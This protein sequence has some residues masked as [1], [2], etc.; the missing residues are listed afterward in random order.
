M[1]GTI[2]MKKNSGNSG[3]V[4]LA[5]IIILVTFLTIKIKPTTIN[6]LESNSDYNSIVHINII[7]LK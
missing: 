1:K 6:D 4:V 2:I 3:L 7:L 5:M